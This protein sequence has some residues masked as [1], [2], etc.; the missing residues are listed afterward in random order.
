M[1]SEIYECIESTPDLCFGD[2]YIIFYFILQVIMKVMQKLV[3][4]Y[5]AKSLKI[6]LVVAA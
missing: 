5:L 1:L 6:H 4:W 2:I 3:K